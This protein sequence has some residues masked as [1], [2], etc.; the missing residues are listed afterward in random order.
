MVFGIAVV[1]F[2]V[3]EGL[4]L[5]REG[6]TTRRM[7]QFIHKMMTDIK[8]PSSINIKDPLLSPAIR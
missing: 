7:R 2:G 8:M 4:D 6:I 5:L 1:L 3:S